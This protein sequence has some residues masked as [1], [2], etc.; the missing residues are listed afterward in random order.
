MTGSV[1]LARNLDTSEHPQCADARRAPRSSFRIQQGGTMSSPR[2][3]PRRLAAVA[4]TC[5]LAAL[6]GTTSTAHATPPPAPSTRPAAIATATA[7]VTLAPTPPMGWNDWAHYQ[8]SVTESV[9]VANA[10]A[11]VSSGLAAK[12][13]KTVTVD[14]CWMASSRDAGGALVAD[15]T[16]FPHGMAWLGSYLHSKGLNFG[17]YEDAGSSTC[18]GYLG[19]GQP[20]GGGADHFAQDAATF[21]SWGV[22]YLKLDGCN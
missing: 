7:A 11:L 18:G 9:V 22:D 21:A 5:A 12:G 13:Y 8:C 14:D 1:R 16:K 3:G 19:S 6:P 17:I 20:Q 15:A 4:L 2:P 10:D